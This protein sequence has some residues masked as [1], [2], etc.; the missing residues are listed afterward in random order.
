MCEA[1][2]KGKP[3]RG[4]AA[5]GSVRVPPPLHPHSVFD[6]MAESLALQSL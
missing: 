4:L 5:V 3:E 2:G 6:E 1:A